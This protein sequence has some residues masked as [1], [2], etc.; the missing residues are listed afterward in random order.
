MKRS[1]IKIDED[2]CN[3]C[4]DCITACV[5]GALQIVNGKAK[6]VSDKYCDGLGMCLG[7][8]PMGAITIIEREADEFDEAAVE[9]KQHSKKHVGHACPGSASHMIQRQPAAQNNVRQ[10]SE[11]TTWPVQITLVSPSAPF[12]Q[13]AHLLIA[14]DCVPFAYPNFHADLLK[15]RILMI[16]CPK[17]DDTQM[18]LEKLSM[19]FESANPQ[20]ITVARMEVPCCSGLTSIVAQALESSGKNIAYNEIILTRDG[21]RLN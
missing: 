1:I 16:G 6:L 7:S 14:A 19:I 20:S 13:N 15:D 8:C 18:Y 11:L 10:S 17:L 21:E 3:G 4:G 5:E 9:A 2:L 12:F